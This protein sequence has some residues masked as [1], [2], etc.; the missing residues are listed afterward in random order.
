VKL[1][2]D[3]LKNAKPAAGGNRAEW[4]DDEEKGLIFRVTAKGDRSWSIRY[5]NA[6]GE[7]RRKTLGPFPAVGLAAARVKARQIRGE[8]ANRVDVVAVEQTARREVQSKRQRTLG[9]LAEAY[10]AAAALGTHI[11]GDARPKSATTIAEDQRVFAKHVR[12][13]FGDTPLADLRRGDIQAF[14]DKETARRKGTGRQCRDVIRQ[15][16]S[17]AVRLGLLEY[18]PAI[19]VGAVAS[20]PRERVLTDDEIRAVW[21]SIIAA[22]RMSAAMKLALRM[23]I[24]TLQRGGQ[25]VGMRWAE[26]D[27]AARTWNL[28]AA[29]MKKRKEHVVPLSDMAMALLDEAEKDVGGKVFV[30]ES[31]ARGEPSAMGRRELSRAMARIISSLGLPRATPH[32]LRRTGDTALTSERLGFSGEV[33]DRVAS[34]VDGSTRGKHYDRNTYLIEKRRALDAWAKLL[35][36]IVS[37]DKRPANV[38]PMRTAAP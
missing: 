16:L 4:R 23:K 26:I 34:R 15:L 21:N 31:P 36:E 28:A 3:F 33:A 19:G 5:I 14:V 30:F 24:V 37:G 2:N 20:M 25:I 7:H 13:K 32:D 10:W 38:V 6:A 22:P 12:P 17:Y 35:G 11:A 18:N 27:R 1:T 9:G 29:R 8:V